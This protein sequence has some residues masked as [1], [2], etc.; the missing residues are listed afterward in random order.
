MKS[1]EWIGMVVAWAFMA[2]FAAHEGMAEPHQFHLPVGKAFFLSGSVNSNTIF[3]PRARVECEVRFVAAGMNLV[4]MIEVFRSPGVL[5]LHHRQRF[6]QQEGSLYC[7]PEEGA[8]GTS[9]L[10]PFLEE[11]QGWPPKSADLHGVRLIASFPCADGTLFEQS[12]IYHRGVQTR[13]RLLDRAVTVR[14]MTVKKK[15]TWPP[16]AFLE[17]EQI[18]IVGVAKL[19]YTFSED[20]QVLVEIQWQEDQLYGCDWKKIKSM[21]KKKAKKIK[22]AS[23]AEIVDAVCEKKPGLRALTSRLVLKLD[24]VEEIKDPFKQPKEPDP[25]GK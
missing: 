13:W 5:D 4:D 17:S 23:L 1:R 6:I 7:C 25:F 3:G 8:D 16:F 11:V 21:F 24:R 22:A 15:T 9:H 10:E 19:L 20:A 18:P 14:T 12:V 2:A